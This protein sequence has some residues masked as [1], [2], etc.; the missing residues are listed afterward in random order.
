MQWQPVLA[1]IGIL[2]CSSCLSV[3]ADS[4][5]HKTPDWRVYRSAPTQEHSREP[6]VNYRPS[7]GR[8]MFKDLKNENDVSLATR[9]LGAVGSRIEFIDRHW[10]RWQYYDGD[11]DPIEKLDLYS[12][13][14]NWSSAF[15]ICRVERYEISFSNTGGIESVTAKPRYG[16]E[17]PIFQKADFDWE[18]SSDACGQVPRSHLP[19]YFPADDFLDAHDIAQ[20]LV[21][22]IDEAAQPKKLTYKL[23]CNKFG[24]RECSPGIRTYLGRLRLDQIDE[25]T[26]INCAYT[27]A[28]EEHCFTVKVGGN[29]IGPFPKYITVRGSNYMSNVKVYSVEVREDTTIS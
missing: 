15:G 12:K 4:T 21:V 25:K 22:A 20:I 9:L 3:D 13:P 16:I 1:F 8:F 29:R 2:F 18:L 7:Q 5:P 26:T 11:D 17:G 28:P 10:D 19:S 6:L 27:T 24:G 23:S 14:E